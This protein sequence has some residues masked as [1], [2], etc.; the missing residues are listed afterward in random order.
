[1]FQPNK[2][3][4]DN[5]NIDDLSSGDET[6]DDERPNKPVPAWAQRQQLLMT[7][8]NQYRQH[9]DFSEMF[10]GCYA[11]Q[12]SISFVVQKISLTFRSDWLISTRSLARWSSLVDVVD[13]STVKRPCGSQWWD[14]TPQRT[15]H[16]T[17][18]SAVSQ[19]KNH[20]HSNEYSTLPHFIV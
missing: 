16:S 8:K 20:D 9:H 1:M 11:Y 15:E 14:Q 6:D 13:Y 18:M 19:E 12:V 5:Y 7:T 17:W 4:A 3:T 2:S 10:T